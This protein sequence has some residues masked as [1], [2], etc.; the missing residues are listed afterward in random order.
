[1]TIEWHPCYKNIVVFSFAGPQS[2]DRS[3]PADLPRVTA[4]FGASRQKQ[5]TS[6]HRV[7]DMGGRR[8]ATEENGGWGEGWG[9]LCCLILCLLLNKV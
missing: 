5:N 8:E 4:V 2:P 7:L 6:D 1:M 3:V 9:T